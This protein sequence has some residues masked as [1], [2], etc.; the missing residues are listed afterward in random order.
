MS[1][2]PAPSLLHPSTFTL[3]KLKQETGWPGF[4]GLINTETVVA[5]LGYYLLSLALYAFLPAQEVQGTEL[6]NGGKLRYRFNGQYWNALF[7]IGGADS[8][9]LSTL[10]SRFLLSWQLEHGYRDLSS[11]SGDSSTTITSH[12]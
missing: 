3:D 1:G 11:L 7:V 6:K 12:Y 10:R 5:T 8:C 2:C 9:Q 4:S